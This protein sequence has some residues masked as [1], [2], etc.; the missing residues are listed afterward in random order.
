M[1]RKREGRTL[2]DLSTGDAE[3]I[4][5]SRQA[6]RD[7]LLQ[8]QLSLDKEQSPFKPSL[9]P[10]L[11]TPDG[12]VGSV[13]RTASAPD[14]Y[15]QRIAERRQ[16]QAQKTEQ[17]KQS[18]ESA[19][20]RE[21]SFQPQTTE[22]PDFVLRIADKRR[23]NRNSSSLAELSSTEASTV[24]SEASGSVG[25]SSARDQ[26]AGMGWNASVSTTAMQ[27]STPARHLRKLKR[28]MTA[29]RAS[30]DGPRAVAPR[31]GS[32]GYGH[33]SGRRGEA[34]R[35]ALEFFGS[36]L[37]GKESGLDSQSRVGG[38]S[39]GKN[40]EESKKGGASPGQWTGRA[41][42]SSP[43]PQALK[44]SV[45][46]GSALTALGTSSHALH[47]SPGLEPAYLQGSVVEETTVRPTALSGTRRD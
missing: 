6:L 44:T 23:L 24:S 15:L 36:G 27:L 13:L 11:V 1:S 14:S 16:Q 37:R 18:R 8:E 41:L 7:L 47:V 17:L 40:D 25:G 46:A 19:E 34:T 21:C 3:R 38:A 32:L 20:L 31:S 30:R 22:A 2:H 33:G 5:Q 29:L 35:R 39:G 12:P 45:A 43:P 42:S 26:C 4:K 9:N 10:D 28:E